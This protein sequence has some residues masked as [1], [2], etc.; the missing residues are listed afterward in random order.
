MPR[1]P[2]NCTPEQKAVYNEYYKNYNKTRYQLDDTYKEKQKEKSR[3]AYQKIKAQKLN[4]PIINQ[5]Q[6]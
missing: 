6:I 3:L 1:K 4:L 2:T 5:D